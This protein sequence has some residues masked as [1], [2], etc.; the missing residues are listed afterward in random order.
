M[1][2][3]KEKCWYFGKTT[4][5]TQSCDC[6]NCSDIVECAEK[7]GIVRSY[8]PNNDIRPVTSTVGRC[9]KSE[10]E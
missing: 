5:A 10:G 7:S 8:N 4:V 6:N 3:G 1:V 2:K 9:W